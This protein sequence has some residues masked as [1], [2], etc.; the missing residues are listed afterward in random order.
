MKLFV[1]QLPVLTRVVVSLLAVFAG[2]S[3]ARADGGVVRLRATDGA[4][5]ATMFTPSDLSRN[6]A[7][8]VTVMLQAQGS[9]EVIVDAIVDLVFI[10]PPGGKMP[11]SDSWCRPL[12]GTLLSGPD[13]ALQKAPS[14][15]ATQG[16]SDNHLL[17]GASVVFPVAGEWQ[18]R[19]TARRGS[20]TVTAT[21]A[22]TVRESSNRLAAVWPWLAMP[23][24]LIGL[25]IVNQRLRRRT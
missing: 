5:V 22:L 1:V 4:I 17:Y 15:R 6:L 14:V 13:S 7:T 9:G 2:T 18:A 8:D 12:R 21:C 16:Q 3:L 24:G 11:A 25:F 10:A 19:M 23:P 20:E